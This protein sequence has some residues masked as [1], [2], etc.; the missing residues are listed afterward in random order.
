MRDP[1]AIQHD[2]TYSVDNGE[3]C[4]AVGRLGFGGPTGLHSSPSALWTG[5][6]GPP[7]LWPDKFGPPELATRQTRTQAQSRKEAC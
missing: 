5:D 1:K 7:A 4:I 3:K 6:L 2:L